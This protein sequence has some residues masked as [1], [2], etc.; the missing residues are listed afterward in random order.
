MTLSM[1]YIIK[2]FALVIGGLLFQTTYARDY[3]ATDFHVIGDGRTLNTEAFQKVIDK[4]SRDGGGRI[5]LT[6]GKYLTGE[7]NLKSNVE[8]HLEKDAV[9]LGS[10]SPYDYFNVESKSAGDELNDNAHLALIVANGAKNIAI[11]GTGV[12]DG[13]GR[14]LALFADSL[15]HKGIYIDK[16]YNNRRQRPSELVRPTLFY[17][18]K[19][20]GIR[21]E[22]VYLRNSSNWGVSLNECDHV[23]F[24]HVDL[25]NRA[26]WN[27][28]G[29]DITDC[30]HV[31]II[32]CNINS[33]DDGICLK[34]YNPES[35][36]DSIRVRD[37]EIRSSASAV[38]FGT[39]SYGGF[40]HIEIRNIRVF[41]TFRSAIA[42]ESVDG[43]VID[44]ILV[45]NISAVNTGNAIFIR[46]GKRGGNRKGVLK[47]VRLANISVQVPFN[48]PDINYDLRGPEVDYL[49]N[50]HPASICGLP[51]EY[52]ENVILENI[53]ITYP[54]RATKGMAYLPLWRLS[55][56]PEKEDQ[57]PEFSMF[58]ELPS[59]G[60]YVRHVRNLTFRNVHL[61]LA[62]FDF[63]P[64]FVLDDAKNVTIENL[65]LPVSKNNS[66]VVLHNSSCRGDIPLSQIV[67][68]P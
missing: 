59:W 41:D 1:E 39:G 66:Q 10:I 28:D 44:D 17:F 18:Y 61:S 27:N 52:I 64:A 12:I 26:Y 55:D 57:Y 40:R 65:S 20:S 36:N 48:R 68:V 8:I 11:T 42:I 15:H 19:T 58:G 13:Q 4:V 6:A 67:N 24:N 53:S 51:G 29:I 38:K 25:F 45:D 46:L 3:I 49:H 31:A 56:I 2:I 21:V 35:G 30:S 33:A 47:N 32:G 22:D 5:I 9:I 54:G 62:D 63:R 34:S 7:I 23:E 14:E 37:C 16:H 50:I 60:F 43:A